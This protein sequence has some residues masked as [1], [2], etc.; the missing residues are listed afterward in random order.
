MDNFSKIPNWTVYDTVPEKKVKEEVH[1]EKVPYIPSDV[2][3]L[4]EFIK[5]IEMKYAVTP[6]KELGDALVHLE[7]SLKLLT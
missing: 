2:T 6:K 3:P 4:K 1:I 7:T 5:E